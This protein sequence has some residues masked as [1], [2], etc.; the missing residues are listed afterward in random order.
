M[1]LLFILIMIVLPLGLIVL[2]VVFLLLRCSNKTEA[3]I[4][5]GFLLISTLIQSFFYLPA[6]YNAA[7]FSSWFLLPML[8]MDLPLS[9]FAVVNGFLWMRERSMK[10]N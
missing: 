2:S 1:T 10:N 8:T 9:L 7:G 5:L 4:F 3:V 6:F